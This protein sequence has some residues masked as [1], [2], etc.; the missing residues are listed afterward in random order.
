MLTHPVDYVD[1]VMVHGAPQ[2]GGEEA[3]GE[4]RHDTN[5]PLPLRALLAT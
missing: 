4:E 3:A 2:L 1:Y 5:T